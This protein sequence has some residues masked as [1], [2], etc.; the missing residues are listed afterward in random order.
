VYYATSSG[1]LKSLPASWTDV[2]APE[3]FIVI[4]AGRCYF[5]PADLWALVELI[6]R[7]AS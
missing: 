6:R 3:P 4:A 5:R 2:D 1:E 7:M